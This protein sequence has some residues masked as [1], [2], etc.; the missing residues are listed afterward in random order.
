MKGKP[1]CFLSTFPSLTCALT[2]VSCLCA[3]K[4]FYAL[5][6]QCVIGACDADDT[7]AT[8]NWTNAKC[9]TA[10]G[11]GGKVKREERTEDRGV[12]WTEAPASSLVPQQHMRVLHPSIL[13]CRMDAE[14]KESVQRPPSRQ[15]SGEQGRGYRRLKFHTWEWE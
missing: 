5:V 9:G 4:N 3:D 10:N 8:L 6:R 2:D 13:P 12:V 14:T 15:P 7:I 1:Q 11:P